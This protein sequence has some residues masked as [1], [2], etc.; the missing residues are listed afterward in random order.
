MPARDKD[1]LALDEKVVDDPKLERLLDQRGAARDQRAAAAAEFDKA[2]QA[3]KA[4]IDALDLGVDTA[5]RV[6]RYRITKTMSEPRAVSF[7][8]ES[9]ERISIGLIGE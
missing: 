9:K 1:Q 5:I 4:A 8:T 2:D 7:E 6:G 3:A